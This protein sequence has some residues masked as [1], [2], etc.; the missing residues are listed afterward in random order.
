[1]NLKVLT[2]AM[3]ALPATVIPVAA[4]PFCT[5]GTGVNLSFGFMIGPQYSEEDRAD[6]A[7]TQLRRHGVDATRVEF[8]NGCLRAF[9]RQPDGSE[10]MEFYDPDTF[11]QVY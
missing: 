1:M 7:R 8:W 4:A 9:V 10:K 5:G 3:L 6:L 2:L 11:Q